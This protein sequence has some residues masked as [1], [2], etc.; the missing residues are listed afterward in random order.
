MKIP[1]P[2]FDGATV[3]AFLC[4]IC[5]FVR[6]DRT[7]MEKHLR[8]EHDDGAIDDFDEVIFLSFTNQC[9]QLGDA[10]DKDR[11]ISVENNDNGGKS[12]RFCIQTFSEVLFHL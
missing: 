2:S 7:G 8:N 4:K 9:E 3:S 10:T 5:N 12:I 11:H 1:Q 6:F